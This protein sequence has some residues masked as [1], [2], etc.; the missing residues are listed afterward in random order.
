MQ[1]PYCT[2]L[3]TYSHNSGHSAWHSV[4]GTCRTRREMGWKVCESIFIP[5]KVVDAVKRQPPSPPALE[6][7]SLDPVTSPHIL[8]RVPWMMIH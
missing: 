8:S 4:T 3:H 1:A 2:A 5:S 7:L 6:P